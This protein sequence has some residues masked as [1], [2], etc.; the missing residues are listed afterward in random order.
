MH[1]HAAVVSPAMTQTLVCQGHSDV[2]MAFG[3]TNNITAVSSKVNDN[4][5]PEEEEEEE[6]EEVVYM[7]Y[8]ASEADRMGHCEA[9][10]VCP[11]SSCSL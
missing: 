2:S 7:L 6:E 10:T 11:S 1:M 4:N 3:N 5:S 9:M 8:T